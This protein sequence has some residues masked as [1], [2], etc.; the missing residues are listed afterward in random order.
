MTGRVVGDD[1]GHQHLEVGVPTELLV[2]ALAV[3]HHDPPE[4]TGSVGAANHDT[5]APVLLRH[6]F[7]FR[8]TPFA[9]LKQL[10]Q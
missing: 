4:V 10:F 1:P 9:L 3:G 7:A 8:N 5:R 6:D 2:V